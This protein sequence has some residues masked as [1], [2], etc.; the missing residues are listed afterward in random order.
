MSRLAMGMAVVMW[1]ATS[2]C[3][4]GLDDD[5]PGAGDGVPAGMTEPHEVVHVG[6][7]DVDILFVMDDSIGIADAA[8]NLDG[9]LA[10]LDGA[11]ASVADD[12][13]MHIGVTSTNVAHPFC[14]EAVD[15]GGTLARQSCRDRLDRFV[16]DAGTDRRDAWCLD[17]CS[18][19]VN[20]PG[21]GSPWLTVTANGIADV[22]GVS[23]RDALACLLPRGIDGCRFVSPLEAARRALVDD[24]A[25]QRGF[26]RAHAD[27]LLVFVTHLYDCSARPLAHLGSARPS[28]GACWHAGVQCY[29]D[30]PL[31]RHCEAADLGTDELRLHDIA[32]Y[33]DTL[34]DIEVGKRVGDPS[35][36]VDVLVVGGVP[37][38]SWGS[39][40]PTFAYWQPA[41]DSGHRPMAMNPNCRSEDPD[42]YGYPHAR[43][44]DVLRDAELSGEREWTPVCHSWSSRLLSRHLSAATTAASACLPSCVADLD[45]Q[46]GG[47]QPR[48]D[49]EQIDPDGRRHP[50]VECARDDHGNYAR[51]DD[52]FVVPAGGTACYV[53]RGDGSGATDDPHDDRPL[54]DGCGPA[55]LVV[56]I[57]VHTAGDQGAALLPGTRVTASCEA[58]ALPV[59]A[60]VD[61][62]E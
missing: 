44:R 46:R 33:A 61:H 27:L 15:D 54:V 59:D 35:R 55:A 62:D 25:H 32:R 14:P 47:V 8:H 16:T 17:R 3:H 36:R 6:E 58:P 19:S 9:L 1:A 11:W 48:C 40:W 49:V 60:C 41:A 29:G 45:P 20:L 7:H 10:S 38:A 22:P 37:E 57:D 30:P 53:V 24:D 13:V 28:P 31:Y 12:R 51:L 4:G 26:L 5:A 56:A 43:L 39:S 18:A 50:L 42:I 34:A 21:A 2:G 52:E 23:L